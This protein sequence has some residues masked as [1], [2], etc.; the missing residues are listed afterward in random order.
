MKTLWVISK[1]FPTDRKK[2]DAKGTVHLEFILHISRAHNFKI[3]TLEH[4]E[5]VL[6]RDTVR[7]GVNLQMFQKMLL[8]P[9]SSAKK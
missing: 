3:S 7:S 5:R 2:R 8:L 6:R 1:L 9:S 4:D